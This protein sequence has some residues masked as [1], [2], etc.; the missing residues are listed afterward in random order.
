MHEDDR[1][2]PDPRVP[3]GEP[4]QIGRSRRRE[5]RPDRTP[6][7]ALWLVY[8]FFMPR[9][10]FRHFV[11]EHTPALTAMCAWLYGVARATGRIDTRISMGRSQGINWNWEGYWATVIIGGVVSG[12]IFY[13]V[14]GWW[15]RV[16]L[17]WSGATDI[18]KPLARR[19]Y[20]YSTV[21]F[22]LP[23]IL[24]KIVDT[25]S[26]ADPMAA[27]ALPGI[28]QMVVVGV[29]PLWSAVVSF[30]GVRTVFPDTGAVRSA[31]WF[32]ALPG[33][34]YGLI[35]IVSAIA[36][37]AVVA[38]IGGAM[39]DVSKSDPFRSDTFGLDVPANW[40]VD[41]ASTGFD[42]DA[43]VP[44]D[45]G[46]DGWVHITTYW[47][48]ETVGTEIDAT[49][50]HTELV[51]DGRGRTSGP[52]FRRWGSLDGVGRTMDFD[53]WPF[54][55]YRCRVFIHEPLEG[56]Y[57]E[58]V[59]VYDREFESGYSPGLEMIRDSFRF[60]LPEGWEASEP[61]TEDAS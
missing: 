40:S 28:P 11:V 42:P 19:V 5:K 3:F 32:L 51:L 29:F 52:G 43:H 12:L 23:I 21:V 53:V 41:Q 49:F 26:Y 4:E 6:S 25:L 45:L 59:E 14:G 17:S 9:R 61:E 10:F 36:I 15:Y 50:D 33:L 35:A 55:A 47:S 48:E 46:G 54:G 39:P 30:L 2:M 38:G 22:A 57:L 27:A 60:T 31:I 7:H 18:D 16:R 8:L 58:V 20:L 44:V 34:I 13:Y 1:P 24:M 56:F 37:L